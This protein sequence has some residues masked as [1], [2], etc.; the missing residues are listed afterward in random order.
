MRNKPICEC[1]GV[2]EAIT[3][4]E[5]GLT[6]KACCMC[7]LIPMGRR[8]RARFL[9]YSRTAE[10]VRTSDRKPR[11]TRRSGSSMKAGCRF[12]SVRRSR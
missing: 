9:P 6:F 8:S 11:L 10:G 1:C 5:I 7:A 3:E 4:V 12:N 2:G